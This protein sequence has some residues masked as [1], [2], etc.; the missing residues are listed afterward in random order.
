MDMSNADVIKYLGSSSRL[1]EILIK[2]KS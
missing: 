1:S 2:K